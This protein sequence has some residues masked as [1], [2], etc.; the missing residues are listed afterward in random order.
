MLAAARPNHGFDIELD[1]PAPASVAA[2][3]RDQPS[4][5]SNLQ[6]SPSPRTSG[7]VPDPS[8]PQLSSKMHLPA[9]QSLVPM[10]ADDLP[11]E[12]LN[13]GPP[14]TPRRSSVAVESTSSPQSSPL[15]F[16]GGRPVIEENA[17][18]GPGLV[19]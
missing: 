10:P 8:L 1:N 12:T 16:R 5:G 17:K 2:P 3:E 15:P 7:L 9:P 19:A 13:T 14:P 11:Q 4:P 6:T 18:D